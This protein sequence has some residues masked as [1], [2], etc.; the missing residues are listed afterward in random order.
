MKAK[1][2]KV[3][4]V[5]DDSDTRLKLKIILNRLGVMQ[6]EEAEN[7]EKGLVKLNESSDKPFHLV[8]SDWNMPQMGGLD[9]LKKL[10]EKHPTLPCFLVTGQSDTNTVMEAKKLGILAYVK[11]PFTVADIKNKL[12]KAMNVEDM[13][14]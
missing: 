1:E 9:M 11:K 7:G 6:V 5:E 8:V 3:L 10:R 12:A 13:A 2:L 14:G 4:I